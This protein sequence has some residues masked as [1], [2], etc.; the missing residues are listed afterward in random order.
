MVMMMMISTTSTLMTTAMATM[1]FMETGDD[2][3]DTC[4]YK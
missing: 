3:D 4:N 1:I 2:Y